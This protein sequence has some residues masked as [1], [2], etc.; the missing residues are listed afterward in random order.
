MAE[1]GVDSVAAEL[2]EEPE[3]LVVAP[4]RDGGTRVRRFF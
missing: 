3:A 2:N 1:R 4:S